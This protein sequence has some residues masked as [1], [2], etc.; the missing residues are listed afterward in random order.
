MSVAI[1]SSL[2]TALVLVAMPS[3]AQPAPDPVETVDDRDLQ[4]EDG[5]PKPDPADLRSGHLLLSAGGGVWAPSQGFTPNIEGFGR[6][7]VGGTVHVDVGYG[8]SR[9]AVL[10]ATA[11]Y[12]R[13][14]GASC[15]G[16]GADSIDAGLRITGII[17]Q[18]FGFEPWASYGIGYRFTSLSFGE[19]PAGTNP[20]DLDGTVHGLDV[21][22]LQ[23][24]GNYF[25]LASFGFGPYLGADIGLRDF[26]SPTVYGAFHGGLRVTFDPMRIGATAR[27]GTTTASR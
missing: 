12:S 26:S 27:P 15:D 17:A 13:M 9:H 18:G 3:S 10:S 23:V 20:D 7:D 21:A 8:L 6:L 1:R 25:P 14:V 22:R 2:V 4:P 11:G 19:G 24:G 5:L 16:C